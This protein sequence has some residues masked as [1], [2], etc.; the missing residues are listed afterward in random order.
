MLSKNELRAIIRCDSAWAGVHAAQLLANTLLNSRISKPV[1]KARGSK[2]HRVP[3]LHISHLPLTLY[4]CLL[5]SGF[6]LAP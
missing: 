3:P 2:G 5:A 6:C 1:Q 4:L